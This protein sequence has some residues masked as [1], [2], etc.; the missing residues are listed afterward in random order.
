MTLDSFPFNWITIYPYF[1]DISIVHPLWLINFL[2]KS[3]LSNILQYA[4]SSGNGISRFEYLGNFQHG[5]KFIDVIK[6]ILKRNFLLYGKDKYLHPYLGIDSIINVMGGNILIQCSTVAIYW[7]SLQC[8]Q[9]QS[10]SIICL[11]IMILNISTERQ[12]QSF[13]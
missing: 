9:R 13:E 5:N 12:Q 6:R 4:V 8:N 11:F 10:L 1:G 3:P 2:S 7:C